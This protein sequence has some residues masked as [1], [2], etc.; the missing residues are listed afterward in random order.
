MSENAVLSGRAG[1]AEVV[2][3][4]GDRAGL[5]A[6]AAGKLVREARA[7]WWRRRLAEFGRLSWIAAPAW[8]TGHRSISIG[9]RVSIWRYSRIEAFNHVPGTVRLR[10]GDGTVIHPFVHI[11]AAK[12]VEIGRGVLFASHVY[13][14][15]HDHDISDPNEPPISN[16]RTLVAPV[17]ICDYVWLGERVS[18]LKGVTIGE[19]S[20]IGAGAIVTRDVPAYSIAVGAPARVV[21]RWDHDRRSW[22]SV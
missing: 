17:R 6:R 10:I 5:I 3:I 9:S 8:V 2:V 12:S 19:R 21:R 16:G 22:V 13:V 7:I 20:V 18:V 15:D 4:A 14:T 11:G 1:A